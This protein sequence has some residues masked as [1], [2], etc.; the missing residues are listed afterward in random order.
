M[1]FHEGGREILTLLGKGYWVAQIPLISNYLTQ[2][3]PDSYLLILGKWWSLH[4]RRFRLIIPPADCKFR[5]QQRIGLGRFDFRS[6]KL[7]SLSVHVISC[8]LSK[9]IAAQNIPEIPA[10]PYSTHSDRH[11]TLHPQR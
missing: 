3:R 4:I 2:K 1:F 6:I 7:A 8:L 10:L 5:L 11:S 9:S